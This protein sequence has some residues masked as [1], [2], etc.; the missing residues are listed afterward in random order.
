M[1]SGWIPF[2]LKIQSGGQKEKE[3]LK[4]NEC[5]ILMKVF[6]LAHI[7]NV[8][9]SEFSFHYG[10]KQSKPLQQQGIPN[11]DHSEFVPGLE[12]HPPFLE[13]QAGL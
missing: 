1:L 13:T 6:V 11:S 8:I 9:N 10:V 7:Q 4:L 12:L 3:K 2:S 5:T